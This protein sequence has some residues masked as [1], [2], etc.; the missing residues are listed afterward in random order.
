MFHCI[1]YPVIF[2]GQ[3]INLYWY[4]NLKL[5]TGHA[6]FCVVY[7]FISLALYFATSLKGQSWAVL[8]F[9]S[10]RYKVPTIKISIKKSYFLLFWFNMKPTRLTGKTMSHYLTRWYKQTYLSNQYF[11][12]NHVLKPTVLRFYVIFRIFLYVIIGYQAGYLNN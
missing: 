11:V 8:G 9:I 1:K 7:Y 4:S 10:K 6:E 5:Y 2:N 12:L 3:K